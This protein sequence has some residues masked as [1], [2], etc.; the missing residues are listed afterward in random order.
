MYKPLRAIVRLFFSYVFKLSFFDG[1]FISFQLYLI[2]NSLI[3]E[4]LFGC[5][6]ISL[7]FNATAIAYWKHLSSLFQIY[8]CFFV[9]YLVRRLYIW[10]TEFKVYFVTF[11]IQQL[12]WIENKIT[13][14]L[15]FLHQFGIFEEKKLKKFINQVINSVLSL[16]ECITTCSS[17]TSLEQIKLI[18]IVN[19]T[20]QITEDQLLHN[21]F[22][23]VKFD[24]GKVFF[25]WQGFIS[26]TITFIF[27][28]ITFSKITYS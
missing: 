15:M 14:S 2:I 26:I 21:I 23:V 4:T 13:S 8:G 24:F 28:I 6:S 19:W 16:F 9:F 5:D 22:Q 1:Y 12:E 17:S 27:N 7:Y 11:A 25:Y 3:F 20:L 10:F 18:A